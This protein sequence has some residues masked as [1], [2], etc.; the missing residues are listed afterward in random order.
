MVWE[1][2]PTSGY[3]LPP[4]TRA[5][6]LAR[7]N[8]ECQIGFADICT[9]VATEVD[10]IVNLASLGL[11]R[12]SNNTPEFLQSTCAPCHRRKTAQE[13]RAAQ[14]RHKRPK[15]VNPGL[16]GNPDYVLPEPPGIRIQRER[17]EQRKRE[18]QAQMAA[19]TEELR[20]LAA[21]FD[22]D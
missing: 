6:V 9:L 1:R 10:H 18:R 2:K 5:F 3:S 17:A 20:R 14:N 16:A 12:G 8:H 15:P 11:P 7:D 19:E 21:E 13:A 4:K 22:K